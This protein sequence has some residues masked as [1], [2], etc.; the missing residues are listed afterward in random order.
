MRSPGVTRRQMLQRMGGLSLAAMMPRWQTTSLKAPDLG[1]DRFLRLTVGNRPYRTG[2]MRLER[3]ALGE[4]TLLHNYGH[5]GEGFSLSWGCA[6]EISRLLQ[7]VTRSSTSVAILGAGVIGLTCARVLRTF[8]HDV[9]IYAKA[10]PPETTSNKSGAMWTPAGYATGSTKE[11]KAQYDRV[12][13]TSWS[14]FEKL[15]N[16]NRAVRTLPVFDLVADRR[17]RTTHSGFH[18]YP[19]TERTNLPLPGRPRHGWEYRSFLIEPPAYLANLLKEVREAGVKVKEKSFSTKDDLA[20]LEETVIVNCL[21][22]GAKEIFGDRRLVPVRGHLVQLEPQPLPYA[23]AFE[24]SYL[25][26]RKDALILGGSWERD[27]SSPEPDPE[28]G[29]RILENHRRFFS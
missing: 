17:W 25:F 15:A 28:T 2:G 8:G 20:E 26:P 13:R 22:L 21:G 4:K 27:V 16:K 24:S 10:L 29:R 11:A 5:G 23:L 18:F 1:D 7:H 6:Q 12:I 19:I 14:H 9:C 3:E